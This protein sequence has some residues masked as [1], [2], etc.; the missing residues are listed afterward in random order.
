LITPKKYTTQITVEP[1]HLDELRHV[2]NVVY[3]EFLQ[4]A[5]IS[6]WYKV[7]PQKVV[8]KIRWVVRK[9]EIEYFK[10]AYER[11]LL[12]VTT[13]IEEFTSVTSVRRYEISRGEEIIVKASTLWV[14]LDAQKMKPI[15]LPTEVAE[16]FFESI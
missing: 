6:H 12:T 1:A 16:S 8:E 7:A 4:Q 2:N 14:A 13:W 3:F 5:A 9:H 10:P 15:R 11:D